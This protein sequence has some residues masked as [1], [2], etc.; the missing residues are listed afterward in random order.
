MNIFEFVNYLDKKGLYDLADQAEKKIFAANFKLTK[1]KVTPQ[2][3]LNNKL[4]AL[5]TQIIDM[6]TQMENSDMAEGDTKIM[7][8][9]KQVEFKEK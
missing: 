9:D 1:K 4:D 7:L 2:Q 3:Q 5:N 6:K 8:D